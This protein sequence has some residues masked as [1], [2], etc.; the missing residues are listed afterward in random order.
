MG[1]CVFHVYKKY[2]NSKTDNMSNIMEKNPY[3][4]SPRGE[5]KET[6]ETKETIWAWLKQILTPKRDRLKTHKYENKTS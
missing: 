6:K 3:P 4:P 5:T 1:L 2:Y